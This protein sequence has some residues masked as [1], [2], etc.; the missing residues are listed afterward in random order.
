MYPVTRA[1]ADYAVED[2]GKEKKKSSPQQQQQQRRRQKNRRSKQYLASLQGG[3][4]SSL[5]NQLYS[6]KASHIAYNSLPP[7]HIGDSEPNMEVVGGVFLRSCPLPTL[8]SHLEST[9]SNGASIP[10]KPARRKIFAPYWSEK[11]VEEA[12]EKRNAFLAT[13][14]VNA[15]NRQEAYCTIDGVPVDVLI[16]GADAQNRAIEGD[17]VAIMLD[18]MAHWTKLKGSGVPNNPT[19][20]DDSNMSLEVRETGGNCSSQELTDVG[21]LL[22]MGRRCHENGSSSESVHVYMENGSQNIYS[23]SNRQKYM[24]PDS[25]NEGCSSR[26]DETA[27]ILERLRVMLSSCPSKRPTGRVV[28]IVRKSPRRGAVVGFLSAMEEH[29]M[30]NDG[31]FLKKGKHIFLPDYVQ[32]LPTDP[33]FPKMVISVSSLPEVAKEKLIN[34]D[35]SLER[36][37]I[38]AQIDEWS[39]E[40]PFPSA[41]VLRTLGRGGEI[42]SQVAAILFENAIYDSN[43]SPESLESLPDLPW[44]VPGK[45]FETRK[46]FRNI[47]TFTIDPFSATDLDDALSVEKVSDEIL[48]VGVHIAD[49]SYF[50]LPD[51]TLDMEAQIRSTSVYILQHKLSMLP[52]ELSEGLC[53]LLP[54]VDRLAFSITWDI[55]RSGK[56]VDRW[57]GRSV[58]QSCCKLSYDLVQEIIDES[59]LPDQSASGSS[60]PN[61]HGLFEWKDIIRSLRNL[62]EISMCLRENRFRDGA[63]WLDTSKLGFLF[64][65]CGTPYDSFLRESKESCFLVEEFMLLANRSVAEVISMAFP[66]CALLRRHPEPNLRKLQDFETFCGKHGFELDISS[67]GQLHLSLSKIREK[68]KDDP[69]LFDVLVSYASRPMQ[70]ATYFCTGEFQDRVDD[71]A[72]YSLSVP[73]YTHFTS[74]LRRYPDIIVHRTLSAALDAEEEY[75]NRRQ[76]LPRLNKEEISGSEIAT[77]CFTG[78]YFS[79]NAVESD[80]GRKALTA[81]ALKFKVSGCDVLSEVAAYCNERKL[82]SRRA[83]EAGEKLSLWTL[84]KKKEI[85][86]SEARVLGLGPRF[87]SVYIHKFGIERR[88]HYDEFEGLGVEW[89]EATSTLVMDL[90]KTKRIPGR[91]YNWKKLRPLEDAALVMYPPEPSDAE[92]GTA[93]N[94]EKKEPSPAMFPLVLRLLSSVSVALHAV[95]GEDGPLDIGARLYTCSYFR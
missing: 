64:D 93:L 70:P 51:T 4:C 65:E 67:S 95:G 77:R 14:R 5:N 80:E 41:R 58:I 90:L 3:G 84:L 34:G 23:K 81:A 62:Y 45:E 27:R 35:M 74:P 13:F 15:H 29:G 55:T 42:E 69:V 9:T 66:D 59:F 61:L 92:A 54:G 79:K 63:L 78:L 89:L 17:M 28:A 73:F 20:A 60:S 85:I 22:P 47:C 8:I 39:D 43:F 24:A 32:L 21:G 33:K 16:N 87:M 12:I 19:V 26:Q 48:R 94:T 40:S 10:A 18:P 38:A 68:L 7:I 53:S 31:Q 86:V 57:I 56:I 71:W 52:P 25:S 2:A 88:I 75:L 44:E 6:E 11:V 37:L 82:A 1:V 30:L 36:E 83:E 76:L 72:H 91:V 46:D 49:V 50:V